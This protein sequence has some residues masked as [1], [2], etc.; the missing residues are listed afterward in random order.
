M[1][2]LRRLI[3]P[4]IKVLDAKAGLMEYVASDETLDSYREIIRADGWRFDLFKKNSPFVDSHNYDSIDCCLGKVVDFAV[5]GKRLVETVK[6]AIDIATNTLAIHGFN[7]AS[8]GYLPAVSVGFFPVKYVS[9]FDSNP[10]AFNQELSA[11]GLKPD[12]VNCPRCIYTEQQQIEL[13][14]CIIGANPNA[15]AKAYKAGVITDGFLD[16]LTTEQTKRNPDLSAV[17]AADAERS[18][19]RQRADFLARFQTA[20]KKT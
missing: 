13:S 2:T 18:R 5:K 1:K 17:H 8:N 11:L 16:F 7:M 15:L 4:E 14:A 12:D 19:Q 10:A 3:H 20:L 9:R 6:W